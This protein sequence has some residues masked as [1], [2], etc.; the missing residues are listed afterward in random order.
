MSADDVRCRPGGLMR[1]CTQTL[2]EKADADLLKQEEGET[3][4]CLYCHK[5]TMV[6]RNGAYEWVGPANEAARP[7][8]HPGADKS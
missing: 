4:T 7:A 2:A 3:V 5:E 8:E 6:F 1:C